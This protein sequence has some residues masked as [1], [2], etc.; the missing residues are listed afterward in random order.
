MA[1]DQLLLQLIK[2]IGVAESRLLLLEESLNEDPVERVE[3]DI[4]Q[5]NVYT[6]VFVQ[7]SADYYDQTLAMRANTLKCSVQQLCKSIIF[8]NTAWV[9]ESEGELEDATNS[10][11]YLVVVQY[12]GK[13]WCC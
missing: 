12:Q 3:S 2:R 5:K 9:K 7:V 4:R 8:E 6:S 13:L 1:E 11:Y 10:R